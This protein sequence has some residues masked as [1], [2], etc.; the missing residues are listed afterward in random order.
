MK[1]RN[2]FINQ[3][4]EFGNMKIETTKTEEIDDFRVIQQEAA[5]SLSCL[6][7]SDRYVKGPCSS[8]ESDGYLVSNTDAGQLFSTKYLLS[9]SFQIARGMNYLSSQK[10]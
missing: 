1:N 3:V 6:P 9:C 4:D 10:V 7:D 8:T 5:T 2:N